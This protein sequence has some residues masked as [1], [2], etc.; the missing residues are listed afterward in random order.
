MDELIIK[1]EDFDYII[2]KTDVWLVY[3]KNNNKA[4]VC[5]VGGF[6]SDDDF[7]YLKLAKKGKSE[8]NG[9]I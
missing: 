4:W 2:K 7:Y 9:R 5:C 3:T 1:K 6:S 8:N